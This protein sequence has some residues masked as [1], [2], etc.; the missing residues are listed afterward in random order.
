MKVTGFVE[1]RG[2]IADVEIGF[3]GTGAQER[4]QRAADTL[5]IRVGRIRMGGWHDEDIRVDLVGLNAMLG[6]ASIA[7][8]GVLPEVRV[9]VSARCADDEDAQAVED[10][11]YAPTLSR[12]SAGG[13]VRSERRRRIEVVS[14]LIRR[15]L[16]ATRTLWTEAS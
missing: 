10:E 5:R 16:V 7:P 12:P 3:A 11:V 15:E 9:H 2:V 13:E 6:G 4:A 8:A 1:A 14:G